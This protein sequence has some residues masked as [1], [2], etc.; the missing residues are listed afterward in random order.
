MQYGD[1]LPAECGPPGQTD[2]EGQERVVTAVEVQ[3]EM[4]EVRK[5]V[6]RKIKE[7]AAG[8]KN[9]SESVQLLQQ[10]KTESWEA[11]SHKVS[12]L[13]E[14]LC[15]FTDRTVDRTRAYCPV[16]GNDS[17]CRRRCVEHGNMVNVR[18]SDLVR[19]G[20]VEGTIARD[21]E[22]VHTVWGTLHKSED[23]GEADFRVAKFC[24]ENRTVP[25]PAENR[26]RCSRRIGQPR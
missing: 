25:Y 6:C 13:V 21:P 5:D 8:L 11:V 12:T 4:D 15:W 16:T 20:E 3:D 9:L 14:K 17:R 7:L 18:T 2:D 23:P 26:S 1:V 22:S 10:D 24:P 19:V